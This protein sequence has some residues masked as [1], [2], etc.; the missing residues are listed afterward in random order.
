MKH[1]LGTAFAVVL[2]AAIMAPNTARSS[3]IINFVET[4]GGVTMTLS[5]S[6]NLTGATSWTGG[7]LQPANVTPLNASL[8]V[9][10]NTQL[11]FGLTGSD[12]NFGPGPQA[13]PA[14]FSGSQFAL[15]ATLGAFGVP[16][17]YT[18]GDLLSSTMIFD[19][20]DFATLGMV[21]GTYVW[22]IPSGDTITLN[23]VPTSIPAPAGL[24]LALAGVGAVALVRR[25]R[26][27]AAV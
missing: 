3:V 20:T 10:G 6:L 9:A 25:R 13:L 2:T 24:P 15:L 7:N 21:V 27:H 17:T 23:I 14:T 4:G 1:F 12:N 8:L 11:F 18:S 16:L 19:A 5:G 26:K 22:S